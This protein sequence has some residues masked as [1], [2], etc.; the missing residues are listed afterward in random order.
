MA[1]AMFVEDPHDREK[2][3]DI[4]AMNRTHEVEQKAFPLPA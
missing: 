4:I 3:G 1:S 2:Q